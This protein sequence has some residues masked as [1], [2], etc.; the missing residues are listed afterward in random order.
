[1]AESSRK[2]FIKHL[3]DAPFLEDSVVNFIF[4]N[5]RNASLSLVPFV[6]AQVYLKNPHG[7]PVPWVTSAAMFFALVGFAL[8]TLNV[9]HA[10]RKLSELRIPI[11]PY[12]TR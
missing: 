11:E 2:S 5:V 8:L 7:E 3:Q 1:M 10:W 12:L 4:N 9:L 6:A